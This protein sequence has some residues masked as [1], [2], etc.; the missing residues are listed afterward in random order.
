MDESKDGKKAESTTLIAAV[1]VIAQQLAAIT[2]QLRRIADA[3]T[4]K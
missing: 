4:A 2:E 3:L 1:L